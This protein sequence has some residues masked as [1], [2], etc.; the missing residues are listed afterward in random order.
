MKPILEV[1]LGRF[2]PYCPDNRKRPT[3]DKT[4]EGH[5]MRVLLLFLNT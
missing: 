4:R 5:P 3:E 2:E 1:G